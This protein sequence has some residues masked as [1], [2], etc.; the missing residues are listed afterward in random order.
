MLK[1]E[2]NNNVTDKIYS[3]IP[4]IRVS[5]YSRGERFL[6]LRNDL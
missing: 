5:N 4:A 3:S 1:V 2:R 6:S